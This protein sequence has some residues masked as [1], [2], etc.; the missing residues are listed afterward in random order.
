M[1]PRETFAQECKGPDARVLIHEMSILFHVMQKLRKRCYSLAVLTSS[2]IF[3]AYNKEK[4]FY[5]ILERLILTVFVLGGEEA[6]KSRGGTCEHVQIKIH[7][8]EIQQDGVALKALLAPL[9]VSRDN[10]TYFLGKLQ[11]I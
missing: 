10:N 1:L 4:G 11:V 6:Y 5:N 2:L 8:L 7:K 3:K 9:T